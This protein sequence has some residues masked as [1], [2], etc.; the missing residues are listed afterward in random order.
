MHPKSQDGVLTPGCIV[1]AGM[2]RSGT[3]L[4][5]GL[6]AQLGVAMGSRLVPADMANPRGYFE[7]LDIVEFHQ[8]VFRAHLPQGNGGHPDWGWTPT[9]VIQP[10]DMTAWVPTASGLIA[11]RAA[12]GGVW[13]FKDPRATLLLDFWDALLPSPVYIGVYREPSRV[14]D[15]MQ[16]LGAPVFLKNPGY[17][18]ALWTLYN[19]RLLDFVQRHRSRC[20]LLNVD[21]IEASLNRLPALLRDQLGL[22]LRATDLRT[23]L[24][25]AL[26]HPREDTSLVAQL[27]HHVWDDAAT[28]YAALEAMADLPAADVGAR[29]ATVFPVPRPPSS[30]ELSIVIPT[31]NDA[32]WV[33]EAIASAWHCAEGRHEVLVLDDGTT[34]PE[35]LRIL[36]RL[37]TAGQP[38]IRQENE[39]LPSARNALIARARGEF[40]LPLDADNRLNRAFVQ[41]A[42]A[43]L[44]A[45]P[46]VGVVYGDR[47]LFGARRQ[48]IAVPEF[49]LHRMLA[50]NYIDAC[51]M[52]RRELWRDVGGYEAQLRLGYEDWEF[53]INAGK[54]GWSFRHLPMIALEYRM[55]PDSL[56]SRAQS[57]E[58]TQQFRELL[59]RKHADLLIR[60]LPDR[61]RWMF[62]QTRSHDADVADLAG[63]RRWVF[64]RYWA[65]A[66]AYTRCSQ[67]VHRG[68][69]ALIRR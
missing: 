48:R 53:W 45:D 3:S 43:V 60:L 37:R 14:A 44:R 33:V 18:W 12:P 13:G 54:R 36:D 63:F 31:C 21:A 6:L 1:V 10:E 67:A 50:G 30:V 17:A 55:R 47:Q 11:Q 69:A 64:R 20:V 34:D 40:I 15:S 26:L 56:V 2:H 65:L 29:S 28:V 27:S 66:S 61:L 5:A 25:P 42:R 16:R 58:G 49:D 68:L 62:A 57:P 24:E 8:R 4:T 51:A 52:F 39:G 7:D 32:T 59:F 41:R 46:Q 19:R 35:S 9:D 23:H 38:V 22:P